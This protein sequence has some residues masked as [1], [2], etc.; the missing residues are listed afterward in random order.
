VQLLAGILICALLV[1]C[2]GTRARPD[3]RDYLEETTGTS[4][5]YVA[6][7]AA[8]V[9]GQPGLAASGRD[10]VYLAPLAVSRSGERSSWLW[11]GVWSTVDRQAR[12]ETAK[13]LRL[14]PLQIVAD[15]EPMD[16]D[17]QSVDSRPADLNRIPYATPVSPTQEL[18]VRVT[19]SQLQ[20][21]GRAHTLVLVDRP[22][23]GA[24]RSWRGDDHAVAVLSHFAE[25]TAGP[26]MD[27][28]PAPGR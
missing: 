5:T 2:G 10:Y 4:V 1:G 11:L 28:I 9:R 22:D 12:D 19:G 7:P 20:R 24:A 8:F 3:V 14:G 17:S 21:L 26:G 16:L 6:T 18:M 25:A 23:G 13:P 15:G 27:S